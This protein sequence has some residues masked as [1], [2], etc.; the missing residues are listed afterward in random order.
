ME[1][2]K[3]F[4]EKLTLRT[5]EYL[6]TELSFAPI[7]KEFTVKE[8]E[9]LEFLDITSMIDLS[10]FFNGTIGLSITKEFAL[11]ILEKAIYGEIPKEQ[12][13]DLVSE[14]VAET[15]NIVLGNILMEYENTIEITAPKTSK[16]AIVVTQDEYKHL[17]CCEVLCENEKIILSYLK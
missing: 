15:L 12:V 9:E 5:I 4:L 6:S 8:V 2:E 1:Q 17:Y 14:S 11:K 16:E 10:G 7:Q 3:E 13:E